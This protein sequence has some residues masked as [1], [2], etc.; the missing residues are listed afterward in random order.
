M[1]DY[2]VKMYAIWYARELYRFT[3]TNKRPTP[4]TLE[5]WREHDCINGLSGL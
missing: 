3:I 5:E 1:N 2:E 4:P